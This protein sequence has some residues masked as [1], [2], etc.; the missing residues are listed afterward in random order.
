MGIVLKRS[1]SR[2]NVVCGLVCVGLCID[3][4]VNVN[5]SGVL[6]VRW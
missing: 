3:V 1:C 4:Q 5:H 6:R 2:V